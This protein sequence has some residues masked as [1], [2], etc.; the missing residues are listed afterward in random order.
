M[1]QK[2]PTNCE[3]L[4]RILSGGISSSEIS[5][6]YGEEDTAKTT[7][8]IQ[9]TITCARLGYKVLFIDC[10]GTFSVERLAQLT[11]SDFTE[12]AERIILSRPKDFREQTAIIDRLP[13]YLTKNFRLVVIDTVTSLYRAEVAEKPEKKFELNRELN[14]QMAWLAQTART[15]KI[16]IITVSQVR[17]ILEEGFSSVTPVANRVLK[18][19]ADTIISMKPTG[20]TR[21]IKVQVE[22]K[23]GR[24]TTDF[25]YL[26][27]DETG[28]TPFTMR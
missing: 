12:I 27:I 10:D 15:Q 21:V 28:L 2:I 9:C 11:P 23:N 4:D 22:K 13:D 16:A 24:E 19:W 1:L 14:R 8:A 18:F 25:C 20:N 17:S 5:L 6:I 7:L 3:A 26:R